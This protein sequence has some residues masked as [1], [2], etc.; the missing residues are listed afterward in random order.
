M[1]A[2]NYQDDFFGEEPKGG[3]NRPAGRLKGYRLI[4]H[5]KLPVEYVV[6]LSI[7]ALILLVVAYAVGVERGKRIQVPA[8]RNAG[9]ALIRERSE[10][11]SFDTDEGRINATSDIIADLTK[12]EKISDAGIVVD[13]DPYEGSR[14]KEGFAEV[15]SPVSAERGSGDISEYILQLASFKSKP[16]AEREIRN[17]K[18]KGI[19]ANME[20]KGDWYQVYAEGYAT[21]DE[22]KKAKYDLSEDYEDCY[23]RKIE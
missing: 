11:E 20:K 1:S 22:A 12:A 21:I 23:I 6:M 3:G 4:P 8:K 2:D 13:R 17:L 10:D 5:I 16:A 19:R 15:S 9:E 18:R 14:D 7:G